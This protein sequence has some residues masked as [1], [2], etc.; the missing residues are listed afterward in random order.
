MN[1]DVAAGADNSPAQRDLSAHMSSSIAAFAWT[2]DPTATK[3]ANGFK[4][5][6]VA[7]GK[8]GQGSENLEL[9]VIGGE[10]GSGVATATIGG[11]REGSPRDEAVAWEKVVERCAFINSITEELGV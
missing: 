2:G 4:E 10:E 8:D 3:G 11:G 5:W 7:F 9:L 6:P 1:E